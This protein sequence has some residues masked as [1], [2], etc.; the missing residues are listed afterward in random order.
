MGLRGKVLLERCCR[1]GFCEKKPG[2]DPVPDRASSS[3]LQN[4]PKAEPIRDAG[5]ASVITY[6]RKGKKHCEAAVRERREKNVRETTL[7]TPKSVKKEGE[8]VLQALEHRFPCS[9]W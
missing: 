9:L 6:L 2:A 7:Q 1:G 3:W 5:G 4:G 8:E